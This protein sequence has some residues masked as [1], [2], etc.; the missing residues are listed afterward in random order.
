LNA[1]EPDEPVE[2]MVDQALAAL[3]L[4]RA[5]RTLAARVL[6]EL[7]RRASLPWW[8]RTFAHW[9]LPAR[10][11]FLAMCAVSIGMAL[12]GA[13]AAAAAVQSLAWARQAGMVLVSGASL[14]ASLVHAALPAWFY[15]GIAIFALLYACLFG[16]GA[17][18]YRTL[19]LQPSRGR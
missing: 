8:R 17:A 1:N 6:G 12:Q 4:R 7:Q 19:Y 15:A 18:A 5:P 10:A 3:P 14:A 9:P 2:R 11:A 13:A 16:L